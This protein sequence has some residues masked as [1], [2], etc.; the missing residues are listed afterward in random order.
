MRTFYSLLL[1]LLLPPAL[2]RL[3]WRGFR[4]PAYRQRWM[5]RLGRFV[6]PTRSGGLWI[7]AVSV[8]EVQAVVPLVRRLLEQRPGLPICIT[9]TTPT[10]SERVRQAFGD[11]VFHVYFPYDLPFAIRGFL[12]RVRPDLL[13]MVETEIWPNLLAVGRRHGLH[14]LLA[15]G[16]LSARSAAAYARL[17][18]FTR[19]TFACLDRV[20]AQS[21]EDA[22]RFIAL[23]VEPARVEVTGSIKFD[24]QIPAS[25][26]EQ[27]E[28][29]RHGW[30]HRPVWVAASTHE[31]ED[32]LL[33][34][35]HRRILETVPQALLVLVP[36]HPERFD[37]VAALVQGQGFA[38]VRRSEGASPTPA[39]EVFLGDTMGEL[40]VFIGAADAV[41]MGGSLVPVGGHNI[42]EAA[43]LGKP[44]VFGPH[45][46]N[47]A[48]ISRLLVEAGAARQVPDADGLPGVLA[49]WLS[50]ASERSRVGEH[51]RRVV[52]EN[53][54]A[55]DRLQARVDAM[56]GGAGAAR[57]AAQ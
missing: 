15:N 26:L 54:G 19:Q 39:T 22:A 18:R 50:D 20:A 13:L 52:A 31:G 42:L 56:L 47:F 55:L 3:W 40:P 17:G 34:A 11:Q 2:L 7:H 49:A 46:F 4:T 33:L 10:G 28:A 21:A 25:V 8:G 53:C 57:G 23:G 41:F 35:A 5:E 44:V 36:R 48:G 43:A 14:T 16:R 37:R 12:E 24:M 29:M 45:M 32:A 6:P 30:G 9:T 27:A 51:G 1:T 38:M